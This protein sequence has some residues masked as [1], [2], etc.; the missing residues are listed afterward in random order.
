MSSAESRRQLLIRPSAHL[1]A[2]TRIMQ[3]R[4]RYRKSDLL[5]RGRFCIVMATVE[6]T[7]DI[8]ASPETV[9]SIITDPSNLPK[10]V[11]DLISNAVHTLNERVLSARR[12]LS[13]SGRVRCS[14]HLVF[15]LFKPF[16]HDLQMFKGHATSK[17]GD[18]G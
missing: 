1:G 4:V 9:W 14:R 7:V 13:C 8:A 18:G 12:L 2:Y 10:L 3:V 17:N 5:G 6:Q 11:P 15:S 16:V